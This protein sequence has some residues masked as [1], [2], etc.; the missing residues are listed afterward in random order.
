[1]LNAPSAGEPWLT[2]NNQAAESSPQGKTAVVKP[3][4]KRACLPG[5]RN[6]GPSSRSRKPSSEAPFLAATGKRA[7]AITSS[8]N[9]ENPSN[10]RLP[11]KPS[12]H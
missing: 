7:R 5:P 2:A 4:K 8:N 1:M 3:S 12:S 11:R 10:S 9:P 6:P